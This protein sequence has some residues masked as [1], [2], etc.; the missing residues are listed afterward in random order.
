MKRLRK[1]D[2]S[3]HHYIRFN[4]L[5]EF[6]ETISGAELTYLSDISTADSY[7]YE[8]ESTRVPS[9]TDLGRGWVYLDAY[10]DTTEQQNTIIVYDGNGA[11]I[12]GSEYMIDYIDGRVITSGTVTPATVTYQYFYVSLVNEWED[13]QAADVPVVVV[14]LESFEKVPFQLGGG[15]RV[16]RRGHLHIFATNRAERD[17]LAELLY[18]GINEKCVPNQDWTTGSMI[19]WD[20]TFNTAYIYALI[21]Y[22]SSLHVE[23]VVS[24]NINPPLMGRMPRRD[25]TMLSDLNRYRARIDF[26]MFYWKE[27]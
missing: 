24:R 9:P 16:P 17:D 11:V 10:G 14:N 12:S 25:L 19:D 13:V 26:D 2:L 27:D 6:I 5:N 23:N 4:V 21:Q 15:K 20:G 18:D 1:E 7:V 3:L 8:V 22:S